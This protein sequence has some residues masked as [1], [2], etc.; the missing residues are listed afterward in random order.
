[1]FVVLAK[2]IVQADATVGERNLAA[3]R[4]IKGDH[5][6]PPRLPDV[7][8]IMRFLTEDTAGVNF[9]ARASTLVAGCPVPSRLHPFGPPKT[10]R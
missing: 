4:R 1:M 2:K 6:P 9:I 10:V 5:R 7:R 3:P 8:F